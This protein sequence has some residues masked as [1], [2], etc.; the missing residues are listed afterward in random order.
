MPRVT[1]SLALS[2]RRARQ[3][4]D[5]SG[6]DAVGI[7]VEQQRHPRRPRAVREQLSEAG[8]GARAD[9]RP[10]SLQVAGQQQQPAGLVDLVVE[11]RRMGFAERPA[12]HPVRA[13][14]RRSARGGVAQTG[15]VDIGRVFSADDQHL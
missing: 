14:G 8:G 5:R 7:E 11:R 1:S 13:A 9:T 15:G 6:P 2:H 10:V 4:S 3:W 12:H